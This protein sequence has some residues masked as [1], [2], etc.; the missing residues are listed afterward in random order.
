MQNYR[1][2]VSISFSDMP[3]SKSNIS[4]SDS[5]KVEGPISANNSRLVIGPSSKDDC[6][7]EDLIDVGEHIIASEISGSW[8]GDGGV[9]NNLGKPK[10]SMPLSIVQH[11]PV[12]TSL[13]LHDPVSTSLF[14]CELIVTI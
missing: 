6:P 14:S 12:S 3:K 9:K 10:F 4:F 5:S 8:D 7:W 2:I 13:V 1:K 11:D